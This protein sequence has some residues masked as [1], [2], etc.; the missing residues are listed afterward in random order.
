MVSALR[1]M[2]IIRECSWTIDAPL[3]RFVVQQHK[4][5]V[6]PPGLAEVHPFVPS[7]HSAEGNGPRVIRSLVF[8]F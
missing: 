8:V 2:K 4:V 1:A 3:Q 6:T 5:V 7:T